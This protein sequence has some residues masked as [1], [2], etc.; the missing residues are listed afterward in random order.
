MAAQLAAPSVRGVEPKDIPQVI[1]FLR[2]QAP[3]LKP[4]STRFL[5]EC[6]WTAEKPDLGYALWHRGE[7]VGFLGAIY[8]ERPLGGRLVRIC[9]LSTWYVRPEFRNASLK[10]LYPILAQRAWSITNLTASPAAQRVMEGLG[11]QMIDRCKLVY[12]PW[13]FPADLFRRGVDLYTDRAEIATVLG[14]VEL[15]YLQDHTPCPV[16]HYLLQR[17]G[18]RSYLVLKRRAFPGHLAFGRFPIRKVKLMWYPCMEVLYLGNPCWAVRHW[19]GL[20]SAVIKRERVLAVV[21]PERLMGPDPPQGVR[22]EHRS[23][24]LARES[25]DC[26]VDNLYSELA[27]FPTA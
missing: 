20:V 19:P 6:H 2:G 12:L 14:G 1:E 26:V 18:E 3:S 23:Y 8:A 25:L 5:F 13:R 27:I 4:E 7:V 15:Q 11:F 17:D 21:A 22:W 16:K 24:L 10:L 9:N